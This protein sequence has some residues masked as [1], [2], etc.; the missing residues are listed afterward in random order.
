MACSSRSQ[1]KPSSVAQSD[2]LQAISHFDGHRNKFRDAGACGPTKKRE[3][4]VR[5]ELIRDNLCAPIPA[6]PQ[7]KERRIMSDKD[8]ADADSYW[9]NLLG[10]PIDPWL[11]ISDS[12]LKECYTA[13]GV[14]SGRWNRSEAMMRFFTAHYAGIPESIAPLIIRHL[15]NLSMTDLLLDCSGFIE[16]DSPDF[17]EA[18]E[19]V[20]KLFSRCRENRND[21]VHSSLVLNIPKRNVD[22]I[23]KPTSTRVAE[24]KVFACTVDDIKRIADDIKRLNGVFVS[25]TYAL[26]CRKNPTKFSNPSRTPADFLQHCKFPLPD[27]LTL[28]APGS[29]PI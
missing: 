4:D 11:G 15:N 25:L 29:V 9:E 27:K 18:I 5:Q 10:F 23:A 8:K 26:E 7:P 21:L 13:L 12:A 14:E 1:S 6:T 17:R 19:F 2:K 16:K 20:C 22:R 28:L 3:L 24:A